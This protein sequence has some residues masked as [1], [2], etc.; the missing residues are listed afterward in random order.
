MLTLDDDGDIT[1]SNRLGH[2]QARTLIAGY[3]EK[4][5]Y[6][7]VLKSVGDSNDFVITHL[8]LNQEQLV[9]AGKVL[10]AGNLYLGGKPG[11]M[12][13]WSYLLNDVEIKLSVPRNSAFQN[14]TIDGEGYHH[15]IKINAVNTKFSTGQLK[16]GIYQI[17]VEKGDTIIETPSGY[18]AFTEESLFEPSSS[19]NSIQNTRL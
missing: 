8:Q 9:A 3:L 4:G 1:K 19:S 11:P 14:V 15:T 7:L 2:P 6:R 13:I 10:L 17:T 5:T 12:T 16:A 18:F